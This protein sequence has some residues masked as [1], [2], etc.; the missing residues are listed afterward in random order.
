MPYNFW[1]WL[2][3]IVVPIFIFSATPNSSQRL[4]L[5]RIILAIGLTYILTNLAVHTHYQ[6]KSTAYNTCQS[7]FPDGA[8]QHHE[9]CGEINILDGG[10]SVF[11][12]YLGW[13]PATAYVGLYELLWRIRYRKQIKVLGTNYKG[14]WFS[15]IAIGF[16]VFLCVVY[17]ITATVG[18][19][20]ARA[21]S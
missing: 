3:L 10:G 16:F 17:P 13:I 19:F 4:R 15:N 12:L 11:Y 14:R 1:G 21:I 2:L 6:I 7:Q 20:I 18:I 8:I 9:E 5:G